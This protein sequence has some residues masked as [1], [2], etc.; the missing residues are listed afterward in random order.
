[1]HYN[2]M[3]VFILLMS[4]SLYGMEDKEVNNAIVPGASYC[5]YEHTTD[6]GQILNRSKM[7]TFYTATGD[8]IKAIPHQHNYSV[9]NAKLDPHAPLPRPT[10]CA[11][12][13]RLGFRGIF[14]Q[15]G[16]SMVRE[17]K[18]LFY[19]KNNN[20]IKDVEFD[21]K[22]NINL[23]DIQTAV[24]GTLDLSNIRPDAIIDKQREDDAFYEHLGS[25]GSCG[26]Q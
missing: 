16:I 20:Y 3:K 12:H 7:V 25:R 22:E 17:S 5:V 14:D 1:M 15:S 13:Y 18:V 26:Q 8:A 19:D 6:R 2:Y 9:I 21:Y 4:C 23:G 10:S 24:D 11:L